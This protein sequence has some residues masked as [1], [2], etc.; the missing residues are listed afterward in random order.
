VFNKIII[1]ITLFFLSFHFFAQEKLKD[2]FNKFYYEN[3]QISSEGTIKNGLP[4]GYWISYYPNGI[5][6]SEGN[7]KKNL[8]DSTWIFYNSYGDIQSKIN[9]KNDKKNGLKITY[10]DSCNVVLEENFLDD[11]KQNFTT[12]YYDAKGKIKWKEINYIDNIE[13]GNSFEYG[14]DGNVIT[15]IYYKKGTLVGKEL[16]NRYDKLHLKTGT[17]KKFYE[18]GK[19]KEESRYATDL[20][21]GYLKEYDQKGKLINATLYID[22]VP[23][24]FAAELAALDIRKEYYPNGAIKYEGLYDVI[25]KP[26]GSCKYFEENGEIE[27]VEIYLHGMLLAKGKIDEKERRQGYWEEYYTDGSIKSKGKYIDGKKID[28]W[29]YFF[30]NG[31]LQ[32]KG[33]YLKEEKPTGLWIWYYDNGNIL[34]EESFRKGLE[35]G[36]LQ[37]LTQ[38]GKIITKGEYIDG[39]KDG[40]WFYEMGDHIEEGNYLNDQKNGPWKYHYTNGKLNFEGNFRDGEPD[41]KHKFYYDNGKLKKE[42][43]YVMGIKSNTWKLYNEL[44]ELTLTIYFKNGVEYKIDGTTIKE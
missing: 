38:E 24:S 42:E 31:K 20:L 9:Y 13:E 43:V 10:S 18:D 28:E 1:F 40:F 8:L 17:W 15:L 26:N 3:G 27:K 44:G 23:Q 41:G 37:E 5:I 36:M 29:I 30:E 25:G 11:I 2:G 35:D 33:T 34:R 32:Q 16:I 39:Q 21:N 22:G 12:Y 7:R 19:L 4:E 14:L 6:K